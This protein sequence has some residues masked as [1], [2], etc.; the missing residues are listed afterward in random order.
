MCS[1]RHLAKQHVATLQ[2]L[3]LRSSRP[4]LSPA[5]VRDEE[6]Q[7]LDYLK[8]RCKHRIKGD[9]A[10]TTGKVNVLLQAH[11]GQLEL[12]GFTLISDKSYINQSAG[13]IAR[14]LFEIFLRKGWCTLS[15]Q[16]L[17]IS[18]S[19]DKQI[20][21]DQSPLWQLTNLAAGSSGGGMLTFE[22]VRKLDD[23]GISVDALCDMGP[24]E[25]GSLV[26][27]PNMGPRV[28]SA[29]H[30][31]PYLHIE[32]TVA[33]VTR[34]IL[35]LTLTI[36]PEFEWID[37]LHGTVAEPW[38]IWVEDGA[39]E[40]MYH[41]E[42]LLVPRRT[43]RA[44]ESL[45]LEFAIPIFEPLP[46][47][48]W[49]R[50]IS[51]RWQGLEVMVPISFKHLVLPERHP[52]H[53]D[54]L[55]LTPLPVTALKNE[56]YQSFYAS[57]F[58]HF[59]PVQTQI[60]HALYHG[61]GNVLLGA[62]TGSGKTVA[63]ELAVFRLF[64]AHPGAKA[65]YIAPLKALV[66]ERMKDWKR[67]FA[68]KLGK[69]VEEL[70]GDYTPDMMA[71]QAADIL[72]TTPE[73]WDSISRS[74]KKRGY[75]QRVGLVIIDEIHLLGEDRGPVLEVIVS[76]MRYVA[77]HTERHIRFVG[78]STALANARDLG[79]WLGIEKVGL[80]NF[81]PSVRPV[82]MEVHVQGF[83]GKHYCP[84]M[85]TMNKPAYAAITTY[86]PDQPAL[87]FVSSRR[88]T[89]L[90]ALELIALC[91]TDEENPKRFLHMPPEELDALTS[92][93]VKDA[94]LRDT[95]A[96][97]IGIHHAGLAESDRTLVEELYLS[98]RI[99]V[100][101]CTSTLAWG[102]NFP[103]HL[104]VVKGTE[105]FDSKIGGYRD[106]PVTDVLQMMGRAGRPQFDTHA[107]AVILV[108]EPKKNFFRKF[109]YEPFPVESK[110]K[111]Q[112]TN[113]INAEIAAGTITSRHDAVDWLTWTYLFRRLLQNPSFYGL[114]D[115]SKEGVRAY[116]YG[117]VDA[118]F[119]ELAESKCIV[120][121]EEAVAKLQALA[122]T[123]SRAAGAASG[124]AGDAEL[125]VPLA[126][127]AVASTT[128]GYIGSY[129]YLEHKS[130]RTF[131]T[132]LGAAPATAPDLAW[133]LCSAEE[134]SELPVRH[135]EDTLNEELASQ[136]PWP[137]APG[138]SFLSPH[139][140]AFLL[141]Q[142]R[143]QHA[144][145]PI[146]DYVN[147]TKSVLDQSLR[148]LN[149][150]VDIAGDGGHLFTA[151]GLQKL[152][153]CVTMSLF[154]SDSTL[155]QL[156]GISGEAIAALQTAFKRPATDQIEL[157]DLFPLPDDRIRS[158][159]AAS[160]VANTAQIA[161]LLQHLRSIPLIEVACKVGAA[162]AVPK[163]AAAR[164][165]ELVVDVP[166]AST[167]VPIT[168]DLRIPNA[169]PKVAITPGFSRKKEWAWWIVVG[170]EAD[171]QLHALKRV[172]LC[173]RGSASHTV[174]VAVPTAAAM[175][176]AYTL[177]VMSDT[178]RGIDK[179]IAL[180]FRPV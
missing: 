137:V 105:F 76:R 71:L 54:L 40:H 179:V 143:L 43:V 34:S 21:W 7:E 167:V 89:R 177:Y 119:A 88:Q 117:L 16:M 106:F 109:L 130:V 115:T 70:T 157:A 123:A 129:Y 30:A 140:K 176:A 96:F 97:G 23:S 20:W 114:E 8:A 19:I 37:R 2:F 178:M 144:P 67:K 107:V 135:N 57:S 28:F 174:Q 61:D 81:R 146:T 139:A 56:A 11:I 73:K 90:T 113:H 149:A 82:P 29:L 162:P 4:F 102:V 116:L 86:S 24:E 31:L 52:P 1:A 9:V 72:I 125:V 158:A 83:P 110:L 25:L 103:A 12:R 63:A 95:L 150:M 120:L 36:T 112:L 111:G 175:G 27:H 41:H 14:A 152:V 69:K 99:Q 18:K 80:Y 118:V 101:V 142:A 39:N 169:I 134:F 153:Q 26:R 77:A 68:E 87:I 6:L 170:T 141:L 74:W 22:I 17:A 161:A 42:Y 62:P 160:S 126:S 171:G 173:A 172:P 151:L 127:D 148:V 98:G 92:A 147:D 60:F 59:N 32:T 53:T 33:P 51:D 124:G 44:R 159:L 55:D 108:H 38:Y 100:L 75:V 91:A 163:P 132:S 79:D 121:G 104:V 93:R 65:V 122:A 49:V 58:S 180:T 156:R 133:A 48:Y 35:R 84:R 66:S 155:W 168:V 85:A 145:L 131:A 47:Q 50:A 128:L 10:N 154:D 64:N 15:A 94:S 138:V 5:Q 136:L 165:G 46:P 3:T 166:A 45:K 13:R 78:L 164:P